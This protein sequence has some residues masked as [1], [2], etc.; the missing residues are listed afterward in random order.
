MV[1]AFEFAHVAVRAGAEV[2]ILHR[3][4]RP[5]QDSIRIWWRCWVSIP[6]RWGCASSSLRKSV[7]LSSV[8]MGSVSSHDH[9]PGAP[10]FAAD[11]AVHGGGTRPKKSTIWIWKRLV[12]R[13]DRAG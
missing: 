13:A 4:A 8:A 3:G 1:H 11:M 6:G 12:W 9:K 10:F 5:L 7:A 2:T